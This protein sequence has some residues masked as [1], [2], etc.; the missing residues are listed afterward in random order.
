MICVGVSRSEAQL[1]WAVVS[2]ARKDTLAPWRPTRGDLADV[3][4]A[5][6]VLT[7]LD[8]RVEEPALLRGREPVRVA[9][10]TEIAV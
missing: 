3:L 9:H 10:G 6:V 5:I 8:E 2:S 7:W 1:V 4:K